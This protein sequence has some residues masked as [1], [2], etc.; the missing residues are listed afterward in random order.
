MHSN[1]GTL[2]A[3]SK[4]CFWLMA[5]FLCCR[6]MALALACTHLIAASEPIKSGSD[7]QL[8]CTF[9][10]TFTGHD[11]LPATHDA[12]TATEVSMQLQCSMYGQDA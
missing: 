5:S 12:W 4:R 7:S 11:A 9:L 2:S 3:D 6:V 8:L 1:Q 10:A